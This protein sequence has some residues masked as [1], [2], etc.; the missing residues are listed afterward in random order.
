MA[1]GRNSFLQKLL[2]DMRNSVITISDE[3]WKVFHA[4]TI[5]DEVCASYALVFLHLAIAANRFTAS[6]FP[7]QHADMWNARTTTF[8]V[9]CIVSCSVLPYAVPYYI[10]ALILSENDVVANLPQMLG[11]AVSVL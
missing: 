10:P 1:L 3:L 11:I 9:L 7:V 2:Y 6:Y 5:V 8:L 4:V